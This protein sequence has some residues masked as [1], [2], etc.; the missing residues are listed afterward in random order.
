MAEIRSLVTGAAGF[1]GKHLVDGLITRGDDVHATDVAD[2]GHRTDV[3]YTQFDITDGDAVKAAVNGMDVVF[4]VASI[5]H[6]KKNNQARVFEVN[7]KGTRILLQA[8]RRAGVKRLVYISSASV[9]YEGKDIEN[10]DETLPYG[11]DQA[12]YADSK[13][14]AEKDVLSDNQ[15]AFLTCAIRPHIVFGPGDTRF[16]PNILRRAQA[17]KLKMGV[18]RQL[19]LSDFTYIDNLIDGILRADAS[20]CSNQKAAGQAYFITNGEPIPFW[21]FVDRV[22]VAL[23]HPKLKGMVPYSVAYA[24]AAIAEFWDTLKGGGI[25]PENGLSRFAVRYMCTHHYFSIEKAKRDLGYAPKV[26]IDEGIRR[27]VA[28]L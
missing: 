18:G 2:A 13:I 10:G 23:G 15:D 8:C 7:H 6:T 20:L 12:P 4:H 22:L 14:E 17:G 21:G 1:V 28:A 26:N 9:V 5:V 3:S 11:Q 25:N 24:A 16:L 19:K 27:T